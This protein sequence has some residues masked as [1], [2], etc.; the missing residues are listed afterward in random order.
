MFFE[1]F[2][3]EIPRRQSAAVVILSKRKETSRQSSSTV[4]LNEKL[5][6]AFS[7][8]FAGKTK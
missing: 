8:K 6:A 1:V 5:A 3:L 4:S 2:R 7:R